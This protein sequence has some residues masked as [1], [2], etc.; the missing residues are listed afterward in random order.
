MTAKEKAAVISN[1]ATLCDVLKVSEQERKE[2]LQGGSIL[3]D[4]DWPSN[5]IVGTKICRRAIQGLVPRYEGY[6]SL[7]DYEKRWW[8]ED[9]K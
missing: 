9:H 6:S 7:T 8:S 2:M 4:L 1:L 5:Y 3:L